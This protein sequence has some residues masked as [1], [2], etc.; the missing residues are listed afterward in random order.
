MEARQGNY[1][2]LLFDNSLAQRIY[3][4][5]VCKELRHEHQEAREIVLFPIF[6]FGSGTQRI[7]IR[8]MRSVTEGGMIGEAKP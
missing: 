1:T 8:G 2:S 4:P 3:L 6:S 5:S 7:P